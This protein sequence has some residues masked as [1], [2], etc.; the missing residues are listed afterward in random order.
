MP[1]A[2]WMPKLKTKLAEVSGLIQVHQYDEL[3]AT[4]LVF[5]CAIIT[6]K[7]GSYSYGTGGPLLADHE[8]QIT[9]YTSAQILPEAHNVAAGFIEPVRNKLAANM[10]LD[11]T[12]KAIS[13][14]S[15]GPTYQGPGQ[16]TYGDKAHVGVA[17][18]YRIFEDETGTYPVSQ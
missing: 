1:I 15:E 2:T 5:P 9:V 16:I 13:P 14:T 11:G 6:L 3:P 18:H 12:V 17:F 8:I 4:L 10:K 7:L